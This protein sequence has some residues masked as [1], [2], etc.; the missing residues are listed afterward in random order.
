ML[1]TTLRANCPLNA[2][3]ALVQHCDNRHHRRWLAAGCTTPCEDAAMKN[4]ICLI[5]GG[6]RGTR[7]YP[8]TKFRSKPAVPVA[9]KYRLIDI[10]ISNC[11]NSGLNRVYVLTQFLSTSLHRHITHTYKFDHFGQGFVEILAAQQTLERADW[12]QGTADAVRQNLRY[13]Q[14]RSIQY[15]LI[16]SGDQLYR[17]DFRQMFQMHS[18]SRADITIATLPVARES[19]AGFGIMRLDDTGRVIEFVEK[20]K[21]AEVI[22][23]FRIDPQWIS[24]R[25]LISRGREHLANMGIYLFNR[26]VLVDLLANHTHTDFGKEIFPASI[27]SH[28][29]QAYLFDGYWEDIGTIRSF[30]K[31]NLDLAAEQPPFELDT[32]DALIFSRPRFLP[33][34]RLLG[35][36]VERSLVAD[37]CTIAPGSRVENSV[38]GLRCR[39]GSGVTIRNS[40]LM[41]ADFYESAADLA[42]NARLGRPAVGIGAESVIERAIIDK[43]CRIGRGVQVMNPDGLLSSAEVD[44]V[45]ICDGIVAVEKEAVLQDGWRL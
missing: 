23:H 13:L 16:L 15:V 21:Q 5:L 9:G 26:D 31:S 25:G 7:L 39:I 33:P 37:G 2:G 40:I 14:E 8:L 1:S 36:S 42:E 20:P 27:Q 22:D 28:H 17:M 30:W 24:S 10:P 12:Y 32:Q 44:G 3:C 6:G 18:E 29:V 11:L 4:L 35:V 45:M 43:N 34:S 38:I 41:G 19:V